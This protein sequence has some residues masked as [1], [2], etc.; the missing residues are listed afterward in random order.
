M[1]PN[2]MAVM[3]SNYNNNKPLYFLFFF[4]PRAPSPSSQAL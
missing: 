1:P 2:S 4:A 3:A